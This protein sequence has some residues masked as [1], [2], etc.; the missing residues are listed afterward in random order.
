MKIN[1]VTYR[2]NRASAT[3]KFVHEH[4]ELTAELGAK[5]TPEAVLE[6]LKA[7]A[8]ELLFPELIGLVDRLR[9]ASPL[10]SKVLSDLD[11]GQLAELYTNHRQL[12][13][14]LFD[15]SVAPRQFLSSLGYN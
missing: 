1:T 8:R 15:G 3:N 4:V 6:Q 11:Q 5:D 7:K 10:V 12:F 9:S 13:Q 2:T 14:A